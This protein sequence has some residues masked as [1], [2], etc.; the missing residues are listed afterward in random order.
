[1]INSLEHESVNFN[2]SLIL[3]WNF[4]LLECISESLNT[5]TNWSVSEVRVLGFNDWIIVTVNNLVKVFG[6]PASHLMQLL[7]INNSIIVDESYESN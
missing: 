4:H 2:S 5:N 7:I 3:I 1:M 6:D